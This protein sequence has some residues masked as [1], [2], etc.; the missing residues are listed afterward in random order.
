[1]RGQEFKLGLYAVGSQFFEEKNFP[2]NQITNNNFRKANLTFLK[3]KLF[4]HSLLQNI[5]YI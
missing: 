1:M 3:K 2:P 5:C 4:P